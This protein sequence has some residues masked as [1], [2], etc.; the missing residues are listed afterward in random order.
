M[1]GDRERCLQAGMDAYL[2]KPVLRDDL[3]SAVARF[4]A[5]GAPAAPT[6]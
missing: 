1:V 3:L 5:R 4:S 2:T 6:P